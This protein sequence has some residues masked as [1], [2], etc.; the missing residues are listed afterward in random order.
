MMPVEPLWRK[1]LCWGSVGIFL[2]LP[3]TI[4]SARLFQ[5]PNI[6]ETINNAPFLL[7]YFQSVTGLVFGLAGLNTVDRVFKNGLGSKAK[8]AKEP[9]NHQ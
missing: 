6:A 4:F 2:L 5:F 1:A 8:G 3:L 7:P 9:I